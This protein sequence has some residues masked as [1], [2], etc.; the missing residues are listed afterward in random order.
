MAGLVPGARRCW[1]G[2]RR[3]APAQPRA[4]PLHV[5]IDHRR[6]VEREQLAEQQAADDGDAERIAQLR[7]GAAFQRQ[8]QRAEQRGQRR[9]HDRAEAQQGR[10]HDRLLGRQTLVALGLDREVDHQNRV[11]LHDAHQQHDADQRDHRQVVAEQHQ[12]QQRADAGR[13][14]GGENGERMDE[15]FV[16]HAEHDVDGDGGGQDQPGLAG[17]RLGEFGGVA[18]IA[19]GHRRRHADLPLRRADQPLTASLS[20]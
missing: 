8:R 20:A 17:Q 11:L 7:A 18:G 2:A 14:Q 6:G 13:G 5:E 1:R 12:R 19:A 9:H 3:R 4:Q 15:A 16:Q 10:L